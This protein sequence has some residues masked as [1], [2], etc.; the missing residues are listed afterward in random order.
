MHAPATFPSNPSASGVRPIASASVPTQ[1]HT[2]EYPP[3]RALLQQQAPRQ[4]RQGVPRVSNSRTPRR[5][6]QVFVRLT[7]REQIELTAQV[8]DS[9]VSVKEYGKTQLEDVSRD[10]PL[11]RQVMVPSA[12]DVACR[13]ACL[14]LCDHARRMSQW[15]TALPP[16]VWAGNTVDTA[17][18]DRCHALVGALS[19]MDGCLR[20]TG[21]RLSGC[22]LPLRGDIT[23]QAATSGSPITRLQ[24]LA[25]DGDH[26]PLPRCLD[27]PSVVKRRER[28]KAQ[29]VDANA[30]QTRVQTS[31]S[32]QEKCARRPGK[33]KM[34]AFDVSQ[35]LHRRLEA[36]ASALQ[37]SLS[38][39]VRLRVLGHTAEAS[40]ARVVVEPP[41]VV[42]PR[43]RTLITVSA[44]VE[45]LVQA[46]MAVTTVCIPGS[47]VAPQNMAWLR[48]ETDRCTVALGTI[49]TL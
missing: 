32:G 22:R 48:Q 40:P 4:P 49:C 21:E 5:R 3:A 45:P 20:A 17:D 15:L 38:D 9:G 28:R 2:S 14:V 26:Q 37:L 47:V 6:Y 23:T 16:G 34:L 25:L 10:H 8:A 46:W 39:L 42:D 33:S 11:G 24:G 18:G 1:Y 19:L 27:A 41:Q 44:L 36:T 30:F 35:D 31:A 43:A 29:R 13:R 7:T 12:H